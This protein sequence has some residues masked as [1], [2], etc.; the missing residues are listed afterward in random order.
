MADLTYMQ[1]RRSGIYEFRKRLPKELARG[2]RAIGSPSRAARTRQ[3]CDR[4]VQ[5][6]TDHFSRH[7]RHGGGQAAGPQGS[8]SGLR[9]SRSRQADRRRRSGS[10]ALGPRL[11]PTPAEIEAETLASL[12]REDEAER[13]EGDARRHLQSREERAQ[14]P[15]LEAVRFGAK[16]MAESHLDVMG[17]EID[18]LREDYRRAFAR[19]DTAII[20]AELRSYLKARQIPIGPTSPFLPSGRPCGPQGPRE[21]LRL[22]CAATG[23]R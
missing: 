17:E 11:C 13:E 14:W 4:A 10:K 2:G 12:L 5:V 19:R 22:A 6:R 16:G 1:R 7:E 21:G 8:P 23:R 18:L 3:P 20:D 15:D 9:A